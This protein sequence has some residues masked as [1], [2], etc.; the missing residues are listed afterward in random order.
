LKRFA[1]RYPSVLSG[2]SQKDHQ[3]SDL[4]VRNNKVNLNGNSITQAKIF[5]GRRRTRIGSSVRAFL[6]SP[7]IDTIRQLT[8]SI[9]SRASAWSSPRASPA[10]SAGSSS[11]RAAH[12]PSPTNQGSFPPLGTAQ[13]QAQP[14][15]TRQPQPQ[16]PSAVDNPQDRVLQALAGLTV[17]TH[18]INLCRFI[19]FIPTISSSFIVSSLFSGRSIG[20]DDHAFYQDS[21]AI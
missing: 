21:S 16:P 17:R 15:G 18:L 6:W 3:K 10:F 9:Y 1:I 12:S 5:Q 2:P 13:G 19:L 7:S 4:L 14:N 11:P 20:H 8:S